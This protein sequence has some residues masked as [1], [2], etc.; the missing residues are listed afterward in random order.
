MR[1]ASLFVLSDARRG[2]GALALHMPCAKAALI[3][4][5]EPNGRAPKEIS[6]AMLSAAWA[7]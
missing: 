1:V 7:R 5:V 2:V 6:P 3:V 4:V